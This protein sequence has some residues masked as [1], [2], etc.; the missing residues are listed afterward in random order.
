[1]ANDTKGEPN[2]KTKLIDDDTSTSDLD[3][4]IEEIKLKQLE[5]LSKLKI[6]QEST[7]D[8]N[9]L[10]FDYESD[11]TERVDE[12]EEN[13]NNVNI[14]LP[15]LESEHIH[16]E[17]QKWCEQELYTLQDF[18]QNYNKTQTENIK[19]LKFYNWYQNWIL[20]DIEDNQ[21]SSN[22]IEP[23]S[24]FYH[25]EEKIKKK[26][27]DVILMV[28]T[29]C[30]GWDSERS[31]MDVLLFF[32]C[33]AA[34]AETKREKN[35]PIFDEQLITTAYHFQQYANAVY[36]GSKKVGQ[37]FFSF[38][39]PFLL[40]PLPSLSRCLSFFLSPLFFFPLEN[41]PRSE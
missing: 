32:L 24:G 14:D 2:E 10:N 8:E 27:G 30:R 36:G 37:Y 29:Y 3:T 6:Y 20:D 25:I 19:N 31:P 1:M 15:Q 40:I 13:K 16:G 38:F 41:F 12:E 4:S 23:R 5:N 21:Q 28:E 26:F 9:S 39:F 22:D 11:E 7:E 17:V 34:F 33:L 18:I 35:Q